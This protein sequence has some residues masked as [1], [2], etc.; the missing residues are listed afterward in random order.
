M[1]EVP[2]QFDVPSNRTVD[3]NGVKTVT[4]KTSGHE[5]SHYTV[6]LACCADGTKLP[7]M[8]IFKGKT[9]P[10]ED[11]PQGVIVHVHDKGWMDQDGMK[12][13][14]EKVWSRRPGGLLCKPALLVLDQFRAHITKNT[15]KIAAEQ[16]TKLAVIPGGLT[17]QLQP[18]GVSINKPFK[19]A[20]RDEWNQWMKSS[21]DNLTPAG[22]SGGR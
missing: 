13:W 21:G 3:D 18:L 15:K 14:F 17:S 2:L 7:P 22:S 10:K 19:A 5:K 4:V 9:M 8:L 12:I 1:D 20:M 11:I 16:K 6:V